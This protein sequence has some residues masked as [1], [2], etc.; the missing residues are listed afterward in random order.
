MKIKSISIKG[1]RTIKDELSFEID[2]RVTLV[3]PNNSGKTN[4]LKA[5][6]AFFTGYDN[7]FDYNYSNDICKG[8]RSIRTS[9]QLTIGD[10]LSPGDDD[11]ID[12]IT[13]IRNTLS[14]PHGSDNEITLYLT[15][16]ENSNPVYRVFPNSKSPKGSD[17]VAYSRL[18]RKLFDYILEKVTIHYIPSEKSV[19][20]L[21]K[22]L[23]EPFLF[24]KLYN[25]MAPSLSN[26]DIELNKVASEINSILAGGKFNG[27]SA[28]FSLPK[29]PE[30]FFRGV[31]FNM[32][33]ANETSVFQKGMGIQ[34]AALMSSFCWI[35]KQE[36]ES[37]KLSLWLLEEPE[38]YLHPEMVE[39][40]LKLLSELSTDAQVIT[41]THSL[42]FV[43]QDP[44]QVI[45]MGL[46]EGWTTS[47]KFKTYHEATKKIRNSLGVRFSDYYN[48]SKF[49]IFVE[50]QT[51]RAYLN[52]VL[53]E[54]EKDE[55]LSKRYPTLLSSELS[56]QD[57]GG[58][59]GL[60]GFLKAT[61]EFIKPERSTVTLFDGDDA[62]DKARKA[63]QRYLGN[64]NIGF[65]SN[66]DFIILRDRFAIEGLLPDEFIKQI[67]S[68]HPGWFDDYAE[69]S[70]GKVLP[71]KIKDGSKDS[72]L[73]KF[74]SII[75]DSPT[76]QWLPRWESV[77]SSCERSLLKQADK[78]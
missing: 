22:G 60:E 72:Y 8:E 71:F 19:G 25:V 44:S 32:K 50:G 7:S 38:S 51:D 78:S 26:L 30:N 5:V 68:E 65:N 77:L 20:D 76:H 55:D 27:L 54:I 35:A 9:I 64:K 45:G 14:I 69:D 23:V 4:T 67:H 37:G 34:S 10:L 74:E 2:R 29:E 39:Q 52:A 15:F 28:S 53:R 70:E 49:N 58:T 42:G 3:G 66:E 57:F 61:Y 17:G 41:T 47:E 31:N 75:L 12:T 43:P 18:V 48:L 16:S 73:K 46:N 24:R 33:D 62:G 13:Q 36:R 63:L 59:S 1:Y 40:C 6:K 11:I 56:I 21:Y